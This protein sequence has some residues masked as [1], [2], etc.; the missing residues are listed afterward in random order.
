MT[1]ILEQW[2]YFVSP[3]YSIK[4]PEYLEDALS[5]TND[6]VKEFLANKSNKVDEIYPV[7]HAGIL[8][9]DRVTPLLDYTINTAWNILD[10]QGYRMQGLSTYFSEVWAQSHRKYSAMDYHVHG[11]CQL[12]AFYFLE[13]PKDC[14]RFQIHDPRPGKIMMDLYE[15]DYS[16]ISKATNIV[17][18]TPEAG[19]LM[20]TNSWLPH[21]FTRN[22]SKVPFKFIHMNISTRPYVG[23]PEYP[24]TAEIV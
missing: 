24:D 2:Q 17:S 15:K 14:P 9:D 10:E 1:D 4:K 22:A 19:T 7:I 23:E 6:S 11:D 21:S 16:E 20:F 18:F 3:V 12:S 8:H 5:A 13:C